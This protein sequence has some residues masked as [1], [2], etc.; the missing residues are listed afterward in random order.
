MKHHRDLTRRSRLALV[1]LL[2]AGLLAV[3]VDGP[4]SHAAPDRAVRRT[5]PAPSHFTHGRV[6]NAWFPLKPGDRYAEA[7]EFAADIEHWL[8]DEPV[9][10][11]RE[12]WTVRARQ[13]R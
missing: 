11:W 6:N 9:N 2:S 12:P 13:R 7:G 4:A 1:G 10:A 8:A 5:H 3:A